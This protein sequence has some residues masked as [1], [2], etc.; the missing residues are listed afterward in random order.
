MV[1]AGRNAIAAAKSTGWWTILD[2]V[3][4]LEEP[5]QLKAAL[6]RNPLARSNWDG[7]PPS[8]RKQMLWWIVT[9]ARDVTRSR[10]IAHVVAEA[11]AGRRAQG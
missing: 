6:D 1:D 5:P 2:Q 11:A 9:A 8:A 4:D 7:F 10:R 3:E